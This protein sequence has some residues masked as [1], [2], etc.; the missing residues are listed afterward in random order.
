MPLAHSRPFSI[1][2]V[3]CGSEKIIPKN[4]SQ[5]PGKSSRQACRLYRPQPSYSGNLASNAALDSLFSAVRRYGPMN[6]AAVTR[7][8]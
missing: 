3:E 2:R 6:A 7:C 4:H 5:K 1:C 8:G